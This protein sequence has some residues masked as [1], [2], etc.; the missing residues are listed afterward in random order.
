MNTDR[1]TVN[2]QAQKPNASEEQKPG[3]NQFSRLESIL[4]TLSVWRTHEGEVYA[5]I[6]SRGHVPVDSAEFHE[7][8]AAEDR[9]RFG[10]KSGLSKHILDQVLLIAKDAAA[11]KPPENI[12]LRVAYHEDCIYVD[13]ANSKNEAVKISK[14]GWQTITGAPVKFRRPTYMAE[15]PAPVPGGSVR[16]LAKYLN[17]ECEEDLHQTVGWVLGAFMPPVGAYPILFLNG[18]QGSAKTTSSRVLKAVCDPEGQNGRDIQ[19]MFRREEDLRAAVRT[20]RVLVFDNA[21]G[22]PR[23]VSDAL[24]R[25][26]T[27]ASLRSRK[28]YTDYTQVSVYAHAPVIVNGIPHLTHHAD[29]ADRSIVIPLPPIAAESRKPE[30]EFWKDFRSDLSKILGAVFD[31]VAAGLRNVADVKLQSLPRIADWAK[32]VTACEEKLPWPQGTIVASYEKRAREVIADA[33]AENPLAVAL[34]GLLEKAKDNRFEGTPTELHNAL[35][36]GLLAGSDSPGGEVPSSASK[37]SEALTRL[38]PQLPAIGIR[39]SRSRTR[40]G[41][42]IIIERIE[43]KGEAS[44]SAHRDSR[45]DQK[46]ET[47]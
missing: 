36:N 21:S 30:A 17:L 18:Q 43:R 4:S 8:L 41:R 15:M 10:S 38:G 5:T 1:K 32:W 31:A 25:I 42:K 47:S 35:S 39:L 13:L 37:L 22:I 45:D 14:D 3:R 9:R 2:K 26:S 11:R 7:F 28:L 16:D 23:A 24:C 20:S 34:T 27:G 29:L 40:Q 12:F 46:E 19:Q 33:L 44:A 6:P